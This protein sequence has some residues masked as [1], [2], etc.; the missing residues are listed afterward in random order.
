[1]LRPAAGAGSRREFCPAQKRSVRCSSSESQ[2]SL[3]SCS[4][5]SGAG[6]RPPTEPHRKGSSSACRVTDSHAHVRKERHVG[7]LAASFDHRHAPA[8]R[9]PTRIRR[10][11]RCPSSPPSMRALPAHVPW[12]SRSLPRH[13]PRLVALSTLSVG[14]PRRRSRTERAMSRQRT[15]RPQPTWSVIHGSSYPRPGQV[16]DASC[17]NCGRPT[18]DTVLGTSMSVTQRDGGRRLA[19]PMPLCAI[20]RGDV[21]HRHGWLPTWCAGCQRWRPFGHQHRDA[22]AV[23]PAASGC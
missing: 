3:F 18:D 14:P 22:L 23:A 12:R 6:T 20:C 15:G 16:T 5:S 13:D 1:M 9:C 4:G 21:L 19:P 7:P 11:G 2:S 8:P 10:R 17:A